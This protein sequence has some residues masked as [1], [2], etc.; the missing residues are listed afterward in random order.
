MTKVNTKV[1]AAAFEPVR[2]EQTVTGSFQMTEQFSTY[3][4]NQIDFLSQ[5]ACNQLGVI[6]NYGNIAAFQTTPSFEQMFGDDM[7]IAYDS[8]QRELK[9]CA[10]TVANSHDMFVQIKPV[11]DVY[12]TQDAQGVKDTVYADTDRNKIQLSEFGYKVVSETS[13]RFTQTMSDISLLHDMFNIVPTTSRKERYEIF[14]VTELNKK[15]SKQQAQSR[16][17]AKFAENKQHNDVVLQLV[18]VAQSTA[19]LV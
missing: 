1:K 16:T 6:A 3:L 7:G 14:V 11:Q 2:T 4:Q 17:E 8:N 10:N 18:K 12:G 15:R 13:E 9:Y 19:H 5:M